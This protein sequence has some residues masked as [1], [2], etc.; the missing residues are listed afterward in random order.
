MD[1]HWTPIQYSPG[2]FRAWAWLA[3]LRG[4]VIAN[5]V[6]AVHARNESFDQLSSIFLGAVFWAWGDW[7]KTGWGNALLE[8]DLDPITRT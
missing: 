3:F 7:F 6:F 2:F 4:A 5:I 8:D 1:I